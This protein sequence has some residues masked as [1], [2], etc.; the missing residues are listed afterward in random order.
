LLDGK[1][2]GFEF[3]CSNEIAKRLG[4]ATAGVFV[5]VDVQRSESKGIDARIVAAARAILSG[6]RDLSVGLGSQPGDGGA[7]VGT[8]FMASSFIDVLRSEMQVAALGARMLSGL[9]G[10]VAIPRQDGK[11]TT[12]WVAEGVAPTESQQLF[13]QLPLTPKTVGAVTEFTRQLL[14]QSAPSIEQLVMADLAAIM[15]RA[16]DKAAI[17][18][19]GSAGQPTGVLNTTGVTEY[20]S[21][22]SGGTFIYPDAVGM[23]S[24]VLEADVRAASS[25]FLTRPGHR[26]TLK[27]RPKIEGSTFPVFMV[28]E[29]NR[30]NGYPVAVSTQVPANALIFGDWSQII[31]AEWGV[32]ELVAN[33]LGSTFRSGNVEVRALQT[34]DIAVRYPQAF[35][36]E[37]AFA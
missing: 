7:L 31:I 5:P 26:G 6:N 22:G 2:D 30:L 24:A 15:A 10:N 19:S 28:G 17:N 36:K 9:V 18:G 16:I 21:T 23:E 13:A 34:V 8:D 29:D 27:T 37:T 25:A 32:L 12:Y 33:T 20:T 35:Q 14:L 11:G 4:R 1:R 3:E